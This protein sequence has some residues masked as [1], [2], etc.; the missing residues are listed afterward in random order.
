MDD[1]AAIAVVV[2]MYNSAELLPGLLESSASGSRA[3]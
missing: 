2:V 3:A 1:G